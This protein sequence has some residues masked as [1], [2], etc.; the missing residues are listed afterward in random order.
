MPS[1]PSGILTETDREFLRAEGDYYEGEYA[2]QKRYQRRQAIRKRI[3]KGLI[4]FYTIMNY[5]DDKQRKLFFREPTESGANSEQEFTVALESLMY[6]L[7]YGCREQG[8][9]FEGLLERTVSNAEQDFHR[10]YSDTEVVADVNLSVEVSKAYKG[11]EELARRLEEGERI[12]ARRI[13]QLPTLGWF[14]IDVEKVD[15]VRLTPTWDRHAESEREIVKTILS[16]YLGIDAEIK[17]VSGESEDSEDSE[18][19]TA[20][21][22]PEEYER[23]S[24]DEIKW[25]P[26]L[27]NENT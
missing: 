16:T 9:D 17:M 3:M 21:I 24:P 23:D 11:V 26:D 22:P 7:Y 15:V 2:R 6:W 19:G 20:A 1:E 10:K 12:D 8:R 13:Y 25:R 14:P 27:D 4:D 5:L 18:Q